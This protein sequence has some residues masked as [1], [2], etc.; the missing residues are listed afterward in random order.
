MLWEK[1]VDTPVRGVVYEGMLPEGEAIARA[2]SQTWQIPLE[3]LDGDPL[4]DDWVRTPP[5]RW[6]ASWPEQEFAFVVPGAAEVRPLRRLARANRPADHLADHRG[7][8]QRS[9]R[10][11]PVR[12]LAFF[13]RESS[14]KRLLPFLSVTEV[15]LNGQPLPL[16]RSVSF[17]PAGT[18]RT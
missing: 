6:T 2:A 1:L 3:V 12:S 14:E 15:D 13:I 5:S 10:R 18:E 17:V 7:V 9:S 16:Q 11:A 4:A 8:G